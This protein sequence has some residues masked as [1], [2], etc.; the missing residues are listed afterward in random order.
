M[1]D[2]HDWFKI[3][4]SFAGLFGVLTF[5]TVGMKDDNKFAKFI[6]VMT[7]TFFAAIVCLAFTARYEVAFIN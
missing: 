7:P 6:R 1:N 5:I 4:Q 2:P 3:I